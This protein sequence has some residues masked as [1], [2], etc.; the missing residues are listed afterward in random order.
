M[1]LTGAATMGASSPL[2]CE[3]AY[4]SMPV[5]TGATATGGAASPTTS[6]ATDSY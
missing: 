2:G 4:F 1:T 6:P 5:P 3:K